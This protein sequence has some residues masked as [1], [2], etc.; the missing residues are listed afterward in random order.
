VTDAIT[1]DLDGLAIAP[2]IDALLAAL[3][4]EQAEMLRALLHERG[5]TEALADVAR[6]VGGSLRLDEVLDLTLRHTTA[7]LGADGAGVTLRDDDELVVVA[8][9][10][11]A[12]PFLDA[13]MPIAASLNGTALRTGAVIVSNDVERDAR[14]HRPFAQL[15]PVERTVVAPMITAHGAIGTLTVINRK[16]E[17]ME[18]DARVLQRLADQVAVAIVNAQL[19]EEAERARREWEVAFDS[20]AVGMLILDETACIRRCNARAVALAGA[21]RS[22][23]LLGRRFHEAV[24]RLPHPPAGCVLASALERGETGRGTQ[25]A[26]SVGKIYD[27]VASPHPDGGVVVTFDDVTSYHLLAERHRRVVETARD[28]I[29]ITAP[30]R[31]I[32]FANPAAVELF[33]YTESALVGMPVATL[34]QSELRE[35][36]AGHESGAL[37]GRPQRYETVIVRSDGE[38]RTVAVSTAP[39]REVGEI[40]GVVASLRDVTEEREARDAVLRSDARYRHLVESATDAIF[41]LDTRGAF[42]SANRATAEIIGVGRDLLIGCQLH[43]L[44]TEED[45]ASAAEHFRAAM[46]GQSRRF[47]CRFIRRNGE[48][49]I[50]SV[51]HTPVVHDEDVVSVLGI[52]RD[53]T[54]DRQ[55][56]EALVRSEAR[57]YRLVESASDGIYTVDTSGCF[58]SV[59]RSLERSVGRSRSELHGR[60]FNELVVPA[61]RDAMMQIFQ[62]ALGGERQRGEMRFVDSRGLVRSGSVTLTPIL[63]DGR[64]TGALGVVRDVTEE[65]HLGEQLLQRE[66]LAAVGQLVSGVAHELN[67]PLAGIAAHAQLLLA[68]P[69]GNKEQQEALVTIGKEA[70]RAAKIV[71]NL[72]LFARQRHPERTVADLNQVVLDTLELR[73]YVLRTAQVE[74]LTDLDPELPLTWA[75]P[76]QLQQV[77]LNLLT[78]AEHAVRGVDGVKRIVVRT[79]AS[80][81][82]L[83]ASIADT[84]PGMAR[85]L[86]DRIFNPF[87]TTKPVGEGTGLG[88]SISDG[89]IREHGGQ[90]RV[91]SVPGGGA[92]FLVELPVV[93]PPKGRTK[94]PTASSGTRR[95]TILIADDEPSIRGAL[96]L[97]LE[98]G[99]HTVHAV[100]SGAEALSQLRE[101]RYDAILLDLR[102]PDMGGEAVFAAIRERHPEHA[103]RVVFASGDTDTERVRELL[104]ALARPYVRKPFALDEVAELLCGGT[105]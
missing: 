56:D 43:E 29:V 94:R 73:R 39:L 76:F 104:R 55:R 80:G 3:P 87:F 69:E 16:V 99:G 101:N 49:R 78:N 33:G 93:D 41:T 11:A 36:V 31:R 26:P 82:R 7:L 9:V 63:E 37:A 89:I 54:M 50:L 88:L 85:E 71:S 105:E 67:N 100:S 14:F 83:V 5:Q 86:L 53:V 79:F 45:S 13:R 74:V 95:R 48:R 38:R 75:D 59:N 72:L 68:S 91:E 97:F 46:A 6:A 20:I 23:E 25:R 10:G 61:D 24:L 27:V 98:K 12:T 90:I 1:P 84:G 103:E 92:T 70:R 8:V 65:R 62:R 102:M 34:V 64:V 47:E 18:E 60:P 30:D 15:A 4:R 58:V 35:D 17:F 22:D 28:A 32:A 66:K 51:T 81:G 40:T 77:F 44:V 52:A 19:F 57:Y 2:P 42:S 21:R 96:A